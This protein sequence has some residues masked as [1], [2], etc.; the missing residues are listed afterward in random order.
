MTAPRT[1]SRKTRDYP[2]FLN[3]TKTSK[4]FEFRVVLSAW[5]DWGTVGP[6]VGWRN[7][8]FFCSSLVSLRGGTA[9]LAPWFHLRIA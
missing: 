9:I 5:L 1:V 2:L 3:N 7:V 8:K 4:L 6:V